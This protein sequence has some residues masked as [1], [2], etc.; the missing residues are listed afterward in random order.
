M[1]MLPSMGT[2]VITLSPRMP[3]DDAE[4]VVRGRLERDEQAAVAGKD[5]RQVRQ[6]RRLADRLRDGPA[7]EVHLWRGQADGVTYLTIAGPV[8]S[9]IRGRTVVGW[10]GLPKVRDGARPSGERATGARPASHPRGSQPAQDR[11]SGS[12]ERP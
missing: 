12:A 1:L 8:A 4:R 2:T 9:R 3:L 7:V 5:Q 11:P 10:W 6:L